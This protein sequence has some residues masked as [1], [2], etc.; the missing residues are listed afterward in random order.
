MS[1]HARPGS[2]P[3][4]K[5]R[6]VGALLTAAA[7]AAPS[8]GSGTYVN[9]HERRSSSASYYYDDGRGSHSLTS[10]L[11]LRTFGTHRSR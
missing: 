7:A 1:S 10:K 9:N 8:D 3:P 2:A 4:A 5:P 6:P 11:N